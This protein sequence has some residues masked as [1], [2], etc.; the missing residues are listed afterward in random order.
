MRIQTLETSG[1]VAVNYPDFLRT[2]VMEAMESWKDF[3]EL[4]LE[5][6]HKLSGGDRISDFGYMMRN[7]GGPKSDSKEQFHVVRSKVDELRERADEIPDRRA[8]AFIDAI[9]TLLEAASPL[10]Q[11]F[12]RSVEERYHVHGFEECVMQSKDEWTFRYLHYFGSETLA[13][14]HVDRGGFTMHLHESEEG[15]EYLDFVDRWRPW[16][17]S[18][19]QTI[20][21]PS[22]GLQYLTRGRLKALCHRVVSTPRTI[23]DGRFAMVA[24][25]DFHQT[26]RYDESHGRLQEKP[27]GFNYYPPFEEFAKLFVLRA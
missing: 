2:C 3:C 21:F 9:D 18:S 26:H 8:G 14:A 25:I 15:G 23:Q 27:P 6:K 16:P 20:I 1:F 10:I 19:E 4:P 11:E 5:I 17:V 22:M 7:D 24:F 13:H 12:A